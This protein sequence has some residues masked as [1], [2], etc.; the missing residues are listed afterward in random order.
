M[1]SLVILVIFLKVSY[2]FVW[3]FLT[4]LVF[5]LYIIVS[6]FVFVSFEPFVSIY[7]CASH[8]FSSFFLK[9]L[10]VCFIFPKER[11]EEG[12][13][14]DDWGGFGRAEEEEEM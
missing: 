6:T 8:A 1:N 5:C 9:L 13:E 14:L 4:L 2:C 12:V 10:F 7:L 11:E 3:A